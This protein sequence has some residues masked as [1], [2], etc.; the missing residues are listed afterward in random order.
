[1]LT[2]ITVPWYDT[3]LIVRTY[4]TGLCERMR[5][6]DIFFD[7]VLANKY[8]AMLVTCLTRYL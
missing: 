1:M 4:V 8:Q 3:S 2:K 6:Y 5:S 7:D